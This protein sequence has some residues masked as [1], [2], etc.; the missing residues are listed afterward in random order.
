MNKKS[1][2]AEIF[3]NFCHT[4]GCLDWHKWFEIVFRK[5]VLR[6]CFVF[7]KKCRRKSADVHPGG[8]KFPKYRFKTH[9]QNTFSKHCLRTHSQS[10]PG[11]EITILR[12]WPQTLVWTCDGFGARVRRLQ[13]KLFVGLKWRLWLFLALLLYLF[14][15]CCCSLL[16]FFFSYFLFFFFTFWL[17]HLDSF[18]LSLLAF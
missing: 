3:N 8:G 12:A 17:V 6:S 11:V 7:F 16:A 13:F 5:C 9:S 2:S 1:R 10:T 14:S 4:L 18:L 15:S